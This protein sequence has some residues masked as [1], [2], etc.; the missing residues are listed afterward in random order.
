[1]DSLIKL[2]KDHASKLSL[3]FGLGVGFFLGDISRRQR[4]P[5]LIHKKVTLGYW[6][7][8][9]LAQPIRYVLEYLSIPYEDKKYASGSNEW[10]SEKEKLQ[11][12]FPNLP[13]LIDGENR[14]SQSQAIL[15][16]LGR[17]YDLLGHTEA[18]QIE[19]DVL[20]GVAGDFGSTMSRFMYDSTLSN[21]FQD[22]LTK[23]GKET[24]D[25]YLARYEAHLGNKSFLTGGHITVVDFLVFEHL[26]I[27]SML[28]EGKLEQYSK[29][30]AYYNRINNLP[31]ISSYRKSN[32]FQSHPVNGASAN[33]K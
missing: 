2:S 25:V 33:W 22:H 23:F 28:F 4:K 24:V 17:K 30:K 15:R 32:R 6:G 9:G 7:I 8:R 5:Q 16:Y 20:F 12:D 21:N 29:L 31:A 13:Y 27:I 11:M 19:V 14:I 18:E 26:D 3:I 1:M 10:A